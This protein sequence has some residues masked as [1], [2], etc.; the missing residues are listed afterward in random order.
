MGRKALFKRALIVARELRAR[1]ARKHYKVDEAK[2]RGRTRRDPE[3]EEQEAREHGFYV[4]NEYRVVP[5]KKIKP[6][7]VWKQE[8]IDRI[9]Q[10]IEKGIPLPPVELT[11]DKSGRYTITDGIHRFNASKEAGFT[12]IPAI[13]PVYVEF[14]GESPEVEETKPEYPP[15]TWVRFHHPVQGFKD[16]YIIELVGKGPDANRYSIVAG[17]DTD[18]DYIGDYQ[19]TDFD[20]IS[21]RQIS[22]MTAANIL[23]HWWV[24]AAFQG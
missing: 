10:A 5:L 20:V 22:P 2:V 3:A 24:E 6:L 11:E 17:N 16:G 21:R 23:N 7:R 15:K 9:Q 8:R 13:V 18:A 19:D 14:E 12:H 1:R 4:Y